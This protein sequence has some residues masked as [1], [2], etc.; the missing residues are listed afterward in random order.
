[1]IL[2]TYAKPLRD[3]VCRTGAAHV[4]SPVLSPGAACSLP[5]CGG[6]LGEGEAALPY[7]ARNRVPGGGGSTGGPAK[8]WAIAIH[9][10]ALGP[11]TERSTSAMFLT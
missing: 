11:V 7:P 5:P 8:H 3:P 2:R 6:G 4:L 10:V 9:R 1:M